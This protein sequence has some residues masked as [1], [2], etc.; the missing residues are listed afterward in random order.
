[1]PVDEST[2]TWG[3][4]VL[5]DSRGFSTPLV[6]VIFRD[7]E[8]WNA[9]TVRANAGGWRR[10]RLA[11]WQRG[12]WDLTPH[13]AVD[14]VGKELVRV[15]TGRASLYAAPPVQTTPMWVSAAREK[16]AVVAFAPPGTLQ[17]EY[18]GPE[19]FGQA[20]AALTADRRLWAGLAPV[21]FDVF[22]R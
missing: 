3:L 17:G 2:P 1:M 5:A 14:V 4:L 6:V 10:P 12:A 9:V 8:Q 13:G 18:T 20:V 16:R 11:D 15:T 19:E 22:H 21:R 7:D